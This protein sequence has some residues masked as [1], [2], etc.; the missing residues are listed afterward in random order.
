MNAL[1]RIVRQQFNRTVR[2]SHH[3]LER[4][5]DVVRGSRSIS[6][7]L[8]NERIDV[9]RSQLSSRQ[10][11]P[12]LA[13]GLQVP[14]VLLLGSLA[15]ASL[16]RRPSG[17]KSFVQRADRI[18]RGRAES[19]LSLSHGVP[20]LGGLGVIWQTDATASVRGAPALLVIEILASSRHDA[21]DVRG[22]ETLDIV[23]ARQEVILAAARLSRE[24]IGDLGPAPAHGAVELEGLR[25]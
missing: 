15:E 3:Y 14:P 22:S 12:R 20:E 6:A 10:I 16:Q 9:P 7:D 23:E 13:Y 2:P 17:L 18:G 1:R 4:R 19:V 24:R 5:R 8:A 11:A 25:Q 21:M